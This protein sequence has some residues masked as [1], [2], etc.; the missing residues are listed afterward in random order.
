MMSQQLKIKLYASASEKMS[1]IRKIAEKIRKV[2]LY[3]VKKHE[4]YEINEVVCDYRLMPEADG[5]EQDMYILISDNETEGF[6]Q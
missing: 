3:Q 2:K 5:R 4:E 6:W 1:K